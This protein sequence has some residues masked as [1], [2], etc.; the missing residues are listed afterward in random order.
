MNLKNY[1]SENYCCLRR[2]SFEEN[3]KGQSYTTSLSA[4]R[5]TTGNDR[6]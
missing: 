3:F 6:K 5:N 4:E 2:K 1:V